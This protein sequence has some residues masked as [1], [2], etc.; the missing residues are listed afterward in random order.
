[1]VDTSESKLCSA[2]DIA[3]GKLSG[4]ADTAMS[5]LNIVDDTFKSDLAV[6]LTLLSQPNW[7]LHETEQCR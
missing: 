7:N 5:R 4:V 3:E 1:V 2:I 6:S